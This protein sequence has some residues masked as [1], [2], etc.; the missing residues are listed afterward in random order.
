MRFG[1]RFNKM[2]GRAKKHRNSLNNKLKKRHLK[3]SKTY[4]KQAT[5]TIR[6]RISLY[7]KL[8]IMIFQINKLHWINFNR[9]LKTNRAINSMKISLQEIGN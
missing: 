1:R 6:H 9:Q 5:N 2:F 7:K 8:V 4:I 3:N